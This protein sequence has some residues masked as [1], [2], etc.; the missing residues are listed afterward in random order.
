VPDS[1]GTPDLPLQDVV[2][3]INKSV[4]NWQS[5]TLDAGLSYLKIN[6][7][8]AAP[9]EA[10]L[11]HINVV[12]FRTDKWCR[13]AEPNNEEMCYGDSAAAITTVFYNSN[14]G[15]PEDGQIVDADIEMNDLNFT[16]VICKTANCGDQRGHNRSG[17]MIA[18]LENTLTHELGHFQGLDHTC[19]DDL[20]KP[21]P[22][23]DQGM[24]IPDCNDVIAHMVPDA[25]Y[26][27]ITTATM[28]NFAS[29]GETIKRSPEA[30]D[31]NGIVGI[32]PKAKDPGVCARPGQA[33]S[34]CTIT[35]GAAPAAV[36]GVA[37]LALALLV[38]SRRIRR[39]TH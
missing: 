21:A 28:Y 39:R 23:D 6:V 27:K 16:F 15:H 25:E 36:T 14:P 2:D 7:D 38:A 32:Y 35:P 12:K 37:L 22:I 8:P 20:S 19:R 17:T 5:V 29:P 1:G 30:D 34:G 26:T 3:T 4:A 24:P 31:I 18:D 13:P 9:E 33:K 10:H 11:D